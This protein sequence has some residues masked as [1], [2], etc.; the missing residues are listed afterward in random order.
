MKSNLNKS[1]VI[2]ELAI[3]NQVPLTKAEEFL[4][5]FFAIIYETLRAGGTVGLSGFG[6]FMVSHRVARLG[7]NPRLPHLKITIRELNTP[8]FRAGVRFKDM[9]KIRH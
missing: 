4:K 6:K 5:H 7:V 1:Q 2:E 3:R 9:V 8:K